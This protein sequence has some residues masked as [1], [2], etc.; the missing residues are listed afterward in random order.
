MQRIDAGLEGWRA[1]GLLGA[2]RGWTARRAGHLVPLRQERVLKNGPFLTRGSYH[3]VVMKS[4]HFF[5][6][7]RSVRQPEVSVTRIPQLEPSSFD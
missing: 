2:F 3:K 1:S 5:A 7:V 4:A 6:V